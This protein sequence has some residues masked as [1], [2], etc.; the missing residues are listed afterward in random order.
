MC[1]NPVIIVYLKF[2]F[3]LSL[4][5]GWIWSVHG[6][7]WNFEH[8]LISEHLFYS[9]NHF[10]CCIKRRRHRKCLFLSRPD[11]IPDIRKQFV[12]NIN[13]ITARGLHYAFWLLPFKSQVFDGHPIWM[14][15]LFSRQLVLHVIDGHYH[16]SW[17]FILIVISEAKNSLKIST[18]I[19]ILLLMLLNNRQFSLACNK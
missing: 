16:Y 12:L 10:G 15:L 6:A 1:Y 9:G 3:Q 8:V 5:F 7:W 13:L 11:L 14:V 19:M 17:I 18:M 2:Y 4:F